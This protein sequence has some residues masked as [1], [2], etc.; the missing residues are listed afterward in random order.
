MARQAC[1]AWV[2][3]TELFVGIQLD[4]V[5]P[6]IVRVIVGFPDV[7]GEKVSSTLKFKKHKNML[8]FL[9]TMIPILPHS[10]FLS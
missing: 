4:P 7:M 10:R 6:T 9:H 5:I 8:P 2:L 3:T 1:E